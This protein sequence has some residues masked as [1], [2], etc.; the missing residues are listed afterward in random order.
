MSR[1][2]RQVVL[3]LLSYTALAV[4]WG[5]RLHAGDEVA[6]KD[7][8][9]METTLKAVAARLA[10]A[11]EPLRQAAL[12][13]LALLPA[14]E[15]RSLHEWHAASAEQRLRQLTVQHGP[16][17]APC[18]LNT[19]L[20]F[21]ELAG[22][23]A[24][25]IDESRLFISA[26][27]DRLEE[28]H[29]VAALEQ[30][31]SQ[32]VAEGTFNLALEIHQRICESPAVSWRNVLALVDIARLAHRPAAALRVVTA[33]LDPVAMRLEG[34]ERDDALDLQVALLL[35]G[36]RYAEA[37]RITLD[38]LAALKPGAA[39]PLRLMQRAL[40]ATQAAGESAELLPWIERHLRTFAEH[41]LTMEEIAGGKPVSASYQRWL[42]ESSFIADRQNHTSIACDGF[43]RLAAAGEIRVLARLHALAT[44]IGRGKELAELLHLLQRRLTVIELTQA[45]ADGGAP[46][47]ARD[48]LSAHLKSQPDLREGWRL[49]TQIDVALRGESS[50]SALWQ[51]FLKR[52]PEDV[53]ALHQLAHAQLRAGQLPE[54]MHALQHVPGESLD[55]PTLRQIAALA[56]QLNDMPTAHRAQQLL[57]QG[58]SSPAIGDVMLLSNLTRQHADEASQTAL[59]EAIARLPAQSA[60]EKSLLEPMTTGEVTQFS[61][62]AKER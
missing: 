13:Q 40:L 17:A 16:V 26:A 52:F 1:S 48:L 25:A 59:A 19:A 12:F 43:F 37:S 28:P 49:L 15:V 42:R 6:D 54:A 51:G 22:P 30:L 58:I 45:L 10:S 38:A 46:G 41:R 11:P 24:L 44:Q 23:D 34:A 29:K 56:I 18:P 5:W 60:F 36:T 7:Q 53:P 20:V 31:A 61:T 32:A 62:A 8:A 2:S 50:S 33:W 21:A 4:A 14:H 27:G 57:V 9:M 39:I 3:L 47:P 55:E 35:E